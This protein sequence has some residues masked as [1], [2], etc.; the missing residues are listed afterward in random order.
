MNILSNPH[1]R[2]FSKF[3]ILVPLLIGIFNFLDLQ[4]D[5]LN[6]IQP[7]LG[8]SLILLILQG[9]ASIIALVIG[10]LYLINNNNISSTKKV[11][12]LILFLLFTSI[13]IPAYWYFNERKKLTNR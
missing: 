8:N 12:W 6:K 1:F 7:H 4:Y 13:S 3:I 5:L 10:L 2:H 9:I 11:I